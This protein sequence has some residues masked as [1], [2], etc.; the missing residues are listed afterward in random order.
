MSR[1]LTLNMS[2]PVFEPF[3]E[4]KRKNKVLFTLIVALAIIL[5]W[6]GA[7]GLM[8]V[9]FDEWFFRGHIFWSNLVALIIGFSVISA[10]GLVLE[11][12]I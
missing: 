12:L 5:F 7:W 8:D 11:K 3:W 9:I 6:K 4:L 10:A 1:L 2:K